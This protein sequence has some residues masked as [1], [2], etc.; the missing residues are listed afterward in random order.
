MTV[1]CILWYNEVVNHTLNT[2]NN[3]SPKQGRFPVFISELIE[4]SDPIMTFDNIM[5]EIEITRY[6]INTTYTVSFR[7]LVLSFRPSK[8]SFRPLKAIV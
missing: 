2:T 7:L 1:V 8:L 3:Y 5:E 6:L 4:I